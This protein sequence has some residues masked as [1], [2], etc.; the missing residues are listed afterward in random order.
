[1]LTLLSFR[2]FILEGKVYKFN[3]SLSSQIIIDVNEF[4]L[5]RS[6]VN[7]MNSLWLYHDFEKYLLIWLHWVLVVAGGIFSAA[8]VAS[9]VW[10]V[11][12]VAPEA[13]GILV[14]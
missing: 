2:E 11:G 5:R 13:C 4:L 12:L 1:M 14:S 10:H 6:F 3:Q 9:L 8:P 7:I